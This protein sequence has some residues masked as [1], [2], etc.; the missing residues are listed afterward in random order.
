MQ[1]NHNLLEEKY[2]TIQEENKRLRSDNSTMRELLSEIIRRG[3]LRND[4]YYRIRT[5]LNVS[6]YDGLE[7]RVE[8]RRADNKDAFDPFDDNEYR[9]GN[10]RRK[11]VQP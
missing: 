8:Q 10:D 4:L 1:R 7:R 6:L 3:T 2:L 9:S 5:M 11:E